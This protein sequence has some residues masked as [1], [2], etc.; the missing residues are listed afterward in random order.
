MIS[1]AILAVIL[2]GASRLLGSSISLV[3]QVQ[4]SSIGDWVSANR[5]ALLKIQKDSV[6]IGYD[7]GEEQQGHSTWYWSSNI[8]PTPVPELLR[9]D[10]TVFSDS[11]RQD[12]VSRA[13]GFIQIK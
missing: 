13:T 11:D 4:Q 6:L 12:E 8:Q 5:L 2:T 3:E 10:I 9:V 1:I 7:D